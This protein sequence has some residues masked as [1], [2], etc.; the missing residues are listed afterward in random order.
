[1]AVDVVAAAAAATAAA[2]A[3]AAVQK[4]SAYLTYPSTCTHISIGLNTYLTS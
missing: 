1:M 4:L 2:T 3:V